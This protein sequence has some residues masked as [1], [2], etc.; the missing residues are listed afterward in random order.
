MALTTN[1]S[2]EDTRR[3]SLNCLQITD[4][5]EEILEFILL[6][7]SPYR[8]L[9]CA[10][11]VNRQWYR[12]VQGSLLSR[13]FLGGGCVRA[14]LITGDFLLTGMCSIGLAYNK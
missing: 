14:V 13:F 5:P 6:H 1:E 3:P 9:R 4:L 8:D 2:V 11:Q 12:L 7:L 10:M